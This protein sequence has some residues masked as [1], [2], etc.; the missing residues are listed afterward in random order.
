MTHL[1]YGGKNEKSDALLRV[2]PSSANIIGAKKIME[3]EIFLQDTQQQLNEILRPFQREVNQKQRLAD[4]I[5]QC[6]RCAGRDDFL[7]LEELLNTKQAQ[8][9]EAEEGLSGCTELFSGLRDYVKAQVEKYRF[10]L[11]EDLMRLAEE[12]DLPIEIDF[13]RFSVLKGIEGEISF[14]R[15]TTTINNKALKSID[16]RRIV[17]ALL[18]LKK[19]LYDRPFDPQAFIDGLY[20][21]YGA[22]CKKGDC[23]KG[24][25]VPIQQFYL[26]Y[27]IS[28]HSKAFFANMDK[29]KF[30]GYSLE[31]FGVD[32][33]RCFEA[34]IGG[35]SNGM[36]MQLRPGRNNSLWLIDSDGERRQI[37]G[38]SFQEKKR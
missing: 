11:N 5:K 31:Q 16:P 29:G 3:N 21:A 9:A 38:I 37:T 10:Q 4:F 13:P 12:A 28:L 34:K 35:T 7:Q 36:M 24:Q 6:L 1:D 23:T 20:A 27:V 17:T 32:I 2:Q 19:Q 26:E 18:R 22:L 25:P 30:R 14:S 15:R 8:Q 33:W